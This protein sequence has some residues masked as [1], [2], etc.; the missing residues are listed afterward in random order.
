M[1]RTRQIHSRSTKRKV[2]LILVQIQF[3]RRDESKSQAGK[4]LLDVGK[5]DEDA[6]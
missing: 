4:T 6:K 3:V 2:A 5:E 1:R